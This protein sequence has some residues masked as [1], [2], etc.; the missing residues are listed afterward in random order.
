MPLLACVDAPGE[1]IAVCAGAREGERPLSK[2]RN[3]M[4]TLNPMY[5]G[6]GGFRAKS[7]LK[8]GS[9]DPLATASR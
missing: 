5:A 6:I 9:V 4:L 1:G 8:V 7:R 2:I 3:G